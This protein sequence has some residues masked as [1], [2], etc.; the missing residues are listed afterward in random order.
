VLIFFPEL[1]LRFWGWSWG[2]IVLM[3]QIGTPAILEI[4]TLLIGIIAI[5]V[6]SISHYLNKLKK[7]NK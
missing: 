4:I 6:W 2:D 7:K 5:V 1:F 3:N